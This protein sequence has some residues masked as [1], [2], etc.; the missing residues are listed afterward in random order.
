MSYWAAL[1]YTVGHW[2][3]VPGLVEACRALPQSA[4][5]HYSTVLGRTGLCYVPPPP[6]AGSGRAH[7]L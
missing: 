3:G 4:E 2:R 6:R 5:P 1:S 7:T